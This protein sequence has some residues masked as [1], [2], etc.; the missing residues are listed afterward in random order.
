VNITG[1]WRRLFGGAEPTVQ[2]QNVDE[3]YTWTRVVGEDAYALEAFRYV[4]DERGRVH[5]LR[6]HNDGWADV[7]PFE[8]VPPV[9]VIPG[10][11]F[12]LL[13][14]QSELDERAFV[15]GADE[16]LRGVYAGDTGLM[17][18]I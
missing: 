12:K 9:A 1:I 2:A 10:P 11:I 8:K 18:G 4:R 14:R 15:R 5:S 6:W 13:R 7:E 16:L 17:S 3:F